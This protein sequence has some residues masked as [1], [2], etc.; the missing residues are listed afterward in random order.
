MNHWLLTAKKLKGQLFLNLSINDKFLK[1]ESRKTRP[2][3]NRCD[4]C[5]FGWKKWWENRII[6]KGATVIDA[7]RPLR[8]IAMDIIKGSKLSK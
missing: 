7:N 3:D 8:E 6:E 1:K 5:Q 2:C 4:N